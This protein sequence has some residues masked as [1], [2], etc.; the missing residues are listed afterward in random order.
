MRMRLLYSTTPI[1]L[2]ICMMGLLGVAY[3]CRPRC[4]HVMGALL[5]VNM[6]R[7]KPHPLVLI[8]QKQAKVSVVMFQFTCRV[9]GLSSVLQG[10]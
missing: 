9:F 8:A 10:A 5:Q 4:V 7:P 6:D 1:I 2:C 3:Q